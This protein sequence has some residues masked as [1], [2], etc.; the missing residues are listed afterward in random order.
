V[1]APVAFASA[2]DRQVRHYA[3]EASGHCLQKVRLLKANSSI[4]ESPSCA[5]YQVFDRRS[6]IHFSM[7]ELLLL[8]LRQVNLVT[9]VAKC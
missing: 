4:N 6:L 5:S 3:H 8:L 9:A 2:C 1:V 7:E